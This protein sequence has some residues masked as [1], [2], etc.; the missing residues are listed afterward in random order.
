MKK[1]KSLLL[2]A[3]TLL[4]IMA[5]GEGREG[6]KFNIV[7]E[8][9]DIDTGM[10]IS[11]ATMTCDYKTKKREFS[12]GERGI[13]T[14]SEINEKFS[15]DVKFEHPN[16]E[17]FKRE[18]KFSQDTTLII[19]LRNKSSI[20]FGDVNIN[21]NSVADKVTAT[22]VGAEKVS[23]GT[24]SKLPALLGERDI[25]RSLSLLPGVRAESEGSS[26]F[27]VRGGTS[28]QNMVL[29]NDAPI[30]NAGHVMGMFS[31]FNDDVIQ[32][33]T[34]YKGLMP[35]QFGGGVS[36]VLDITTKRGDKKDFKFGVDIGV[37]FSKFYA[38]GPIIEDKLSFV[39]AG[40]RSYFDA[41][42][43]FSD[44]YEGNTVNF[45]DI[46]AVVNYQ[47][48]KNNVIT[49]SL[50]NG[51]DN[52][53]LDELMGMSW[54]NTA[55]TLR[56]SHTYNDKLYSNTS[57]IWSAFNLNNDIAAP[58]ME[59]SFDGHIKNYSL[60]HNFTL[61]PY[62][63]WN[64]FDFGFQA[65][66]I[67]LTS[68]DWMIYDINQYEQRSGAE[69]TVWLN[70]EIK[71]NDRLK[72]LAG[73]RVNYY[74][75][76]GG[77]PYYSLAENGDII[78]VIN[79]GKY[80]SVAT[81]L[82]FEPRLSFNYQLSDTK[83]IKGGYSRTVQ[84]IHALRSTMSSSPFD[85]YIL[86]S[87]II[88]P[89]IADQFTLGAVT[90]SKDSR[91]QFS[92][93]GYY[94]TIDNV[95]D[96][97]EGKNFNSEVEIERIISGGEGRSYG[98]EFLAQKVKGKFTGWIGYTLS[99]TENKIYGINNGEWYTANNDR[100]HDF[101]VVAMYELSEEWNFSASWIYMTGKA[102]TAPTAWYIMDGKPY[103]YYSE[104]NGY[105]E[106]DTHRLDI[107]VTNRKVKKKYIR[108]W[109]FGVYN[110]YNRY[111]PY[112]V[113]TDKDNIMVSGIKTEQHSI[114]GILPS[115]SLSIRF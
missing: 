13:I 109:K 98:L 16:Y 59:F 114:F 106:P 61:I 87:N 72:V 49:L 102:L 68:A 86:S 36:S 33:V 85:R 73:M 47:I 20:D 28:S 27:E 30:Y 15:E 48:N 26:G 29:L 63:G 6:R 84:N 31:M 107:G 17:P 24:M 1:K 51:K 82:H 76:L 67:D 58:G 80:E 105:R 42:L 92:L 43:V 10:P 75:S 57:L 5:N 113:G 37:L 35:A 19:A 112:I 93:E 50:F 83:S 39:V 115:I 4:T 46:N 9:V 8:V 79:K 11:Y 38:E 2:I 95:Y 111:N 34:L 64:K 99:W 69:I 81:H 91:Y 55:S 110:L 14:I 44:E 62:N 103:L 65:T 18:L 53:G 77:S 3:L 108:E 104:R 60:K 90:K 96:Y 56:W 100:R 74:S 97:S 22:Q 45:Y 54:D 78:S 101:S 32:D 88:E 70:D 40:R 66:L 89:Q 23:V 21:S 52:M 7:I 71:V 94:K 25:V 12:G 41:F